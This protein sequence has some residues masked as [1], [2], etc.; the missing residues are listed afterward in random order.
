MTDRTEWERRI[1]EVRP[2]FEVVGF[3]LT[4]VTWTSL[5]VVTSFMVIRGYGTPAEPLAAMGMQGVILYSIFAIPFVAIACLSSVT[6]LLAVWGLLLS[7]KHDL[8]YGSNK[9]V[10][11]LVSALSRVWHYAFAC[12]LLIMIAVLVIQILY[13]TGQAV[14]PRANACDK[15]AT[16]A[17]T[18]AEN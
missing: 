4:A 9:V 1:A 5:C 17:C 13:A 15:D 18:K 11:F 6:L 3:V 16:Y 7:L 10:G 2:L 14:P 12:F 8:E